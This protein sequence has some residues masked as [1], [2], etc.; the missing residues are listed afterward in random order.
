MTMKIEI[1]NEMHE[2]SFC[3]ILNAALRQ[4]SEKP[5]LSFGDRQFSYADVDQAS[6]KVANSL[7][8]AGFAVGMK[9][10]IY[11]L[12][13][14]QAFIV[15]LGIV[16]AGGIWMPVNPRNSEADNI[17]CL[18]QLGCD[19][20]F[21]QGRF[22]AAADTL[23]QSC[24][25][26]KAFVKLDDDLNGAPPN[27]SC[28][29]ASASTLVPELWVSGSDLLSIPTT[30]GTTG[31]PKGVMLSHRNFCAIDFATRTSYL[32]HGSVMLCAAPMTHAVG[33]LA[34]T[35]L[36][37]GVHLVVLDKV[38]PQLI[39]SSIQDQGITDLFL[40]PTSIYALLDQP[41]LKD[42]NLSSLRCLSYG[43]APMSIERL[44]EALLKLGPVMRGGYGQTECP[45][46][47]T[48]L[49]Q[50][51]HF[52]DGEIAPDS[53]LRSVGRST[54]I[55]KL[56]ILDEF[57]RELPC[58]ERGEIAVKGGNVCEGYYNNFQETADIRFNGWH[59]TGDIGY[60]DGDGFLFI[61]DRK[62]D[63]IIS[64]GFNVYSV[65]VE[66]AL[67]TLP[68]VREAVV[69]GVPSKKWGEEVKALILPKADFDLDPATLIS[70]CKQLLGSVKTP[71]SIEIVDAFPTTAI[72]KVD[73]KRLRKNYWGLQVNQI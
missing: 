5:C 61:V 68:G 31:R 9:A 52:V 19:A 17:D 72:G 3:E 38:D 18:S 45:T 36:S 27:L 53:R 33:R 51:D 58:G 46:F 29:T 47:I 2:G 48:A 44:R 13:S 34:M 30:G 55:S 24:S 56:T 73:K 65:E 39:L 4:F 15:T 50:E 59:L 8:E 49:L 35:S 40:P 42:F 69:F 11:S 6:A 70:A 63:M 66:Q 26:M 25:E 32:K 57:G 22:A 71:K 12:N 21:Y 14:D 23:R 37:S 16:R 60:L 28:W 41:N 67:M 1:S 20:L 64:G 7:R 10:A 43:S 54:C 62:K